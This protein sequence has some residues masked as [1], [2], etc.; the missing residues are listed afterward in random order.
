MTLGE[1]IKA[2][3]NACNLTQQKMADTL[4]LKRNT[5]ASYEIG[6]VQPSDRTIADICRIYNVSEEWLRNGGGQMFI[7]LD[8]D[9]ELAMIF[10]AIEDSEDDLIKDFIKAYWLLEP[11]E[12]KILR[13]IIDGMKKK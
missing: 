6:Q 8:E 10:A 1:R 7:A 2:V 3:R 4:Q 12:K 9:T 13:K 11:E 5:V